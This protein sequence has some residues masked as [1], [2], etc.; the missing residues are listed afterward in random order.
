MASGYA[1]KRQVHDPHSYPHYQGLDAKLIC[2]GTYLSPG[3]SVV[4]P[5][6]CFLAYSFLRFLMQYLTRCYPF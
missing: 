2:F 3:D 6:P 4:A 5:E 1:T